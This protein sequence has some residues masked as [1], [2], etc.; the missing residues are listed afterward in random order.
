M[1]KSD[2][3]IEPEWPE[4]PEH[5]SEKAKK[6]FRFYVGKT[7][8]APG[9]IALLIRGLEAMDEA[10]ECG[11]II[12]A[13]GLAQTSERSGLMRQ[14]PLLNSQREATAQMIKVWHAL[15]L[16][17]NASGNLFGDELV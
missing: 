7:V 3:P 2:K 13:E 17:S 16:C 15:R 5:L 4:P 10:D 6:L 11:R 9:Q 1:K 8:R 14:N 12:R